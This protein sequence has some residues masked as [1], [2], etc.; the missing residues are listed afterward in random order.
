MK[1]TGQTK[2]NKT[3]NQKSNGNYIPEELLDNQYIH[4]E[5]YDK[6]YLD[7][8]IKHIA[9]P[10][11]KIW[12][13]SKLIGWDTFPERN[14][15]EKPLLFATNHSGMA[16]PW[17]AMIFGS[18]I[19]KIIDSDSF[20]FRALTAPMLSQSTLM[21]PYSIPD[22][23][24]RNGGIDATFQNFETM[25]YAKDYNLLIYPEGVPGIGKGFNKRYQ[26]QQ[27]KTSIVRMSIKHRTDIITFATINAEFINPY[28]YS[29]NFINKIINKIGIPF[30]P[31]SPLTIFILLQPWFFYF[32]FPAQLNFVL[33]KRIKPYE[34]T[35]K[36]YDEISQDEF[37]EIAN[38][39]HTI[40]Q[41]ELTDAKE[42]YGK[43][44]YDLKGFFK[45]IFKKP[46]YFFAGFALT[47]PVLL[48]EFGRQYKKDK[49]NI[50]IK[51]G[52]FRNIWL[53]LRNP[54]T[55]SF[56]IP[57]LGWIPIMI[58][59]YKKNTLGKK[60]SGTKTGQSHLK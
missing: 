14:N 40:M 4:D 24:K 6:E 34:M 5:Y 55:I 45:T 59:G 52:F 12:F 31:L 1:K 19:T 37:K 51:T 11:D 20:S 28:S 30:L 42:K 35:D 53:M 48:Y 26:L 32:A 22:F 43:K 60:K 16:F 21:N 23:W 13:R 44:P 54:F 9:K 8:V 15:P 3:E 29:S 58:K 46:K 57:I 38:K 47:W 41:K 49:D 36:S 50:N 27:V 18:K 39:V 25:M 33:G 10:I 2:L 7:A 56:F 17:D